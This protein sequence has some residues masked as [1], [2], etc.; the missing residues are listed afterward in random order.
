MEY[1]K[2][3]G[4]GMILAWMLGAASSSAAPPTLAKTEKR[5]PVNVNAKFARM[6]FVERTYADSLSSNLQTTLTPGALR[7]KS[8]V[9]LII[10]ASGGKEFFPL[11]RHVREFGDEKQ[12]AEFMQQTFHLDPADGGRQYGSYLRV[13]DSYVYDPKP[14]LAYRVDDPILAHIGGARGVVKVGGKTYCIDPDGRCDSDMASYLVPVGQ[15]TAPTDRDV[16]GT[17][18]AGTPVC[19]H[20]HTFYNWTWFFGVYVR[21]GTNVNFT[22]WAALPSSEIHL[23]FELSG[24]GS[25][26]TRSSVTVGQNSAELAIYCWGDCPANVANAQN[27]CSDNVVID[28]DLSSSPVT[29]GN[30][31]LNFPEFFFCSSGT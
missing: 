10:D 27:I 23:N 31:P 8:G 12:L 25:P 16:C 11:E 7:R 4:I 14:G 28:P 3:L 20:H 1:G 13:G 30:G 29:T 6:G 21:H 17:V 18:I 22:T 24:G 19:V 5:Q 9:N 2:S 26:V 15:P